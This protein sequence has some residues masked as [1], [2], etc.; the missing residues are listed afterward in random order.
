MEI[1]GPDF[2]TLVSRIETKA[3][4]TG[5]EEIHKLKIMKERRRDADAPFSKLLD[6]FFDFRGVHT[7]IDSAKLISG[8]VIANWV[9][10][11]KTRMRFKEQ[12]KDMILRQSQVS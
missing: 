9:L 8:R 2:N 5:N 10:N 4:R 7:V 6:V 12:V 1:S 11:N 3:M